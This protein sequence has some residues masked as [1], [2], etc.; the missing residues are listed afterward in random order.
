MSKAVFNSMTNWGLN[1]SLTVKCDLT[2]FILR[3][4]KMYADT[5][6][7]QLALEFLKSIA[8]STRVDVAM[9]QIK[10][11]ARA[12]LN[13]DEKSTFINQ[14]WDSIKSLKIDMSGFSKSCQPCDET[15]KRKTGRWT[16]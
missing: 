8:Q 13:I 11:Q 10:I 6:A 12:E 1:F 5:F 7:M 14:Y 15:N 9:Q 2:D 4:K 16:T 3:S